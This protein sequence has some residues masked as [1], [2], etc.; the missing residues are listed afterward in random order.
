MSEHSW[1]F[2][3]DNRT[4]DEVKVDYDLGKH[5]E[6]LIMEN[7]PYRW[8][9]VNGND[10]FKKMGK[11]EPDYFIYAGSKWYPA[12]VKF[13]GVELTYID[14]KVNQADA[15]AEINGVYIQATPTRWIIVGST[16]MQQEEVV[17]GYC[18]KP[19]YR[20]ITKPDK[21]KVWQHTINFKRK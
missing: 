8:Y 7:L 18:N 9:Q 14:L 15:L 12:E 17:T 16:F 2:S 5:N 13:T 20:Y 6:P 10:E 11:Y 3:K 1:N 21:W 19:C 4:D